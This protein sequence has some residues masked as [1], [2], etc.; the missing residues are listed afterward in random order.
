MKIVNKKDIQNFT[1]KN[2]IKF[3]LKYGEYDIFDKTLNKKIKQF[4]FC[5]LND[6]N[7][8]NNNIYKYSKFSKEKLLLYILQL[9]RNNKVEN[10]SNE[11]SELNNNELK[12]DI[13]YLKTQNSKLEKTLKNLT[14]KI[15]KLEKE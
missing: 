6:S 15:N 13:E 2:D 11:I 4:G 10:N 14:I 7:L 9:L 5:D 3:N 8:C 12:G 1:E